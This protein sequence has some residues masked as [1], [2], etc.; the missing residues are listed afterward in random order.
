MSFPSTDRQY[1]ASVRLAE[2]PNVTAAI[3]AH[4]LL[5]QHGHLDAALNF[6]SRASASL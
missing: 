6:L 1:R 4:P 3:R 5:P 2:P